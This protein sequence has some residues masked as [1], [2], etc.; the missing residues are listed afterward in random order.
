[1]LPKCKMQRQRDC[2][3]RNHGHREPSQFRNLA[4][5]RDGEKLARYRALEEQTRDPCVNS[6]I[7]GVR[8]QDLHVGAMVEASGPA[9]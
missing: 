6:Q 8:S 1:M 4:Q 9:I 5:E 3:C 7:L 2:A